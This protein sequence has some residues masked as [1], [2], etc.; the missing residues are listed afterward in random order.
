MRKGFVKQERGFSEG[1]TRRR[2]VS[3]TPIP[4]EDDA[5][6]RERWA[7]ETDA[8]FAVFA[9]TPAAERRA[10]RK[11]EESPEI[12]RMRR[13]QWLTDLGTAFETAAS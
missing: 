2:A 4:A 6:R 8:A 10:R 9:G 11:V 1:P 3:R 13:Q 12:L 7:T 5:A